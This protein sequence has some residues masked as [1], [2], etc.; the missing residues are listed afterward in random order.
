MYNNLNK[1]NISNNKATNNQFHHNNKKKKNK[2]MI[3]KLIKWLQK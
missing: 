2:T 3:W 1:I